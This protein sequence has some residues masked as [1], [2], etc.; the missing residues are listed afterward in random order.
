MNVY[1]ILKIIRNSILI[2]HV[3]HRLHGG[4]REMAEN[5]EMIIS[6]PSGVNLPGK[7]HNL[8]KDIVVIL[9]HGLGTNGLKK[10]SHNYDKWIA[11]AWKTLK[12][13]N[14]VGIVAYTARGH[15]ESSGWED[16]AEEYQQFTWKNLAEDMICV[17]DSFH[18]SKY[19][20]GGQSMG[21][22]T[23]LY[24]AIQHPEKVSGLI[25]I[26]PPTAWHVRSARRGHLEQ[27]A[28][29]S[30]LRHPDEPNYNVFLGASI[31][32][33]P[34][35]DSPEYSLVTCPVLI[36]CHEGDTAH[37]VETA[38]TLARLIPHAQLY[39]AKNQTEALEQFP[40]ILTQFVVRNYIGGQC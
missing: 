14:Q 8:D 34:P 21:A 35:L 15:G 27:I 30:K 6:L 40:Q 39:I 5:E 10:R 37:P 9:G 18:L 31:S 17:G 13:V 23:A 38:A 26:R 28:Q 4:P 7:R 2:S 1:L 29:E 24:A 12:E 19:I 22:S 11:M 3:T 33:L 36:L 25:L 32:D 16:Y 20:V